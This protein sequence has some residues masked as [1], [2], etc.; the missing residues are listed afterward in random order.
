MSKDDSSSD[1]EK[2]PEGLGD[3]LDPMQVADSEVELEIE[4]SDETETSAAD[5]NG[6]PGETETS[7]VAEDE[8]SGETETS[9]VAESEGSGETETP[10]RSTS[11][12]ETAPILVRLIQFSVNS[13]ARGRGRLLLVATATGRQ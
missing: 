7:A 1:K 5:E 11:A 3:D 4:T 10:A 2:G 12:A 6:G 13:V 8:G 9:K